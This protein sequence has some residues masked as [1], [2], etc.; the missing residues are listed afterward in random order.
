[1]AAEDYIDDFGYDY[2]DQQYDDYREEF[3]P[4]RFLNKRGTFDVAKRVA[5]KKID[6][7]KQTLIKVGNHLINPNEVRSISEVKKNLY[8]IRFCNENNPQYATWVDN[9][10]DIAVLLRHFNIIVED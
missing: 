2:M 3:A 4:F 5:T 1:M 9:E 8:I 7:N 6:L 10:K